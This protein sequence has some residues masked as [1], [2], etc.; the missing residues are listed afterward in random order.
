[1]YSFLDGGSIYS[2]CGT[3]L[4]VQD[5]HDKLYQNINKILEYCAD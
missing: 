3:M 1:L 5:D 4:H 2:I